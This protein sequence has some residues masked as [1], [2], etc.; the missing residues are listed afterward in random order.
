MTP[1]PFLD[2]GQFRWALVPG[3]QE[4]PDAMTGGSWTVTRST[5]W[6]WT[7]AVHIGEA[8]SLVRGPT[9]AGGS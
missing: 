9:G 3:F 8:R 4:V 5:P 1:P 6:C 7:D 2:D